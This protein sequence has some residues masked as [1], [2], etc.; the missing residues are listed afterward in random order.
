MDAPFM[1]GG[2]VV[3]LSQEETADILFSQCMYVHSNRKVLECDIPE[4]DEIGSYRI[5]YSFD[6][7]KNFIET[8][9]T[10]YV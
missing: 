3:K 7:A 5:S 9:H 2:Y 4:F 6:G 8:S 10:L 1:K